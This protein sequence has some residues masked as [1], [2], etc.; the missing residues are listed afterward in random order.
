MATAAEARTA[1]AWRQPDR[2]PA[3]STG[4]RARRQSYPK[5]CGLQ[6]RQGSSG[7]P[8]PF[9]RGQAEAQKG[10]DSAAAPQR[11]ERGTAKAWT[12]QQLLSAMWCGKRQPLR[13][14]GRPD[15]LRGEGMLHPAAPATCKTRTDFDLVGVELRWHGG[16]GW[17][18]MNP[19]SGR[20]KKVA[21]LPPPNRKPKDRKSRLQRR[22]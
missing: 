9:T 11:P 19:D 4:E 17:C 14:N 16:G 5:A 21:P 12:R 8:S 3:Q 1:L 15:G 7:P 18:R 2:R 20:P 22:I 10:S 13:R 6:S